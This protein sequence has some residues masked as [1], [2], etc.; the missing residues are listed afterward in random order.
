MITMLKTR[1]LIAAILLALAAPGCAA[2]SYSSGM[3][4]PDVMA[5]SADYGGGDA[6]G[7]ADY[8]EMEEAAPS[9]PMAPPAE[10]SPA[11]DMDFKRSERS[12]STGSSAGLAPAGSSVPERTRG[13]V[14]RE[15][16]KPSKPAAKESGSSA[17]PGKDESKEPEKVSRQIIYTAEMH[18]SVFKLDEAMARVEALALDVGGYVQ[19]MREG[20]Y[21][22]RVPAA[23]LRDVMNGVG[24][25]GMVTQRSLQ[26]RDVT[27]EFV[28][29]TTRIRVL[30]ETQ[31]QLIDLLKK[32]KTVEEALHV[33]QALDQ[34]T[35]EL[36]QALGRLRMLENLIGFSTLTVYLEERGPQ[37]NIPSSNDPFPWVDGLGVE[38]TEWN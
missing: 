26:A 33:R 9:A 23:R 13:P 19:Q 25:L 27:E 10:P 12:A 31:L 16:A 37:N 1:T 22:I 36:E 28:D 7:V 4:A 8:Y 24:G 32:A 30:R 3:S 21:V 38:A 14:N 6:D 35:M 11:M 20:F 2:K 29:L 17:E 15:D 18:L 5:E 34:V